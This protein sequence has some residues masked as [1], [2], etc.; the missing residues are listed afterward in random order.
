MTLTC[1]NQATIHITSNLVFHKRTKH[2]EIYYAD[3]KI[4]KILSLHREKILSRD[5][6]TQFVNS[7]DQLANTRTKQL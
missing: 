2:I 6:K 3:K 7:N 5:I 1:D 4:S